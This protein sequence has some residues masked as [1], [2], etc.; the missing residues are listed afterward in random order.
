MNCVGCK[1]RL[2][3]VKSC[4]TSIIVRMGIG[5]GV[6]VGRVGRVSCRLCMRKGTFC[7]MIAIR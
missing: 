3:R 5:V 1:G 2:I 7:R 4:R 6:G